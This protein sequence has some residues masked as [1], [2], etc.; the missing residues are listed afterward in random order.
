MSAFPAA[1]LWALLMIT[2][3]VV[4]IYQLTARWED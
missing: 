1:P 2:L 4:I 3:D